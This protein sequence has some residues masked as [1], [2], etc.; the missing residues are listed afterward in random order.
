M[1][2]PGDAELNQRIV[3][4]ITES[5]DVPADPFVIR[6]CA[7]TE[8]GVG[9]KEIGALTADELKQFLEDYTLPDRFDLDA[10]SGNDF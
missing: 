7:L 8:Q 5:N 4:M 6:S 2:V 1:F 9:C 10:L 3:K